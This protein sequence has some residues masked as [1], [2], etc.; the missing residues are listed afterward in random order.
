MCYAVL[1]LSCL[2]LCNHMGPSRFLCPWGLSRQ[3]YW[4]VLPCPPPRDL[5][6]EG[7]EPRSPKLQADSLPSEPTGKPIFLLFCLENV[8]VLMNLKRQEAPESLKTLCSWVIR[9]IQ[10]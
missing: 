3:E 9:K 7:I 4:S 6:N 1:S 10:E 5:S 2:T 8:M